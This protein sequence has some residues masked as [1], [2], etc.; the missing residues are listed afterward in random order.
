[1]VSNIILSEIESFHS[2][3]NEVVQ[4]LFGDEEMKI[5]SSV[6]ISPETEEFILQMD[7]HQMKKDYL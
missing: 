3:F 1:M 7:L 2:I 4:V 6:L 5:I